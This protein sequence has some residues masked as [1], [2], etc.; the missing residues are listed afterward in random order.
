MNRLDECILVEKGALTDCSV[1]AHPIQPGKNKTTMTYTSRLA[2]HS[3]T[4]LDLREPL[5]SLEYIFLL[6]SSFSLHRAWV[7][8]AFMHNAVV[9]IV[10]NYDQCLP[11]L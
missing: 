3:E 1:N 8:L 7:Q 11:T 5:V 6:S 10:Y 2:L 9:Y 4:S